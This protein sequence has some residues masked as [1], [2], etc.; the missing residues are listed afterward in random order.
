MTQNI[1][2]LEEIAIQPSSA[3]NSKVM[4]KITIS[5]V[6]LLVLIYII[7]AGINLNQQRILSNL[8]TTQKNLSAKISSYQQETT[9]FKEGSSRDLSGLPPSSGNL[10]GF[11]NHLNDLTNITP[12]GVWLNYINISGSDVTTIKGGTI[13]TLGISEFINAL[14]KTNSWLNKKFYILQL[15]KNTES[16]NTDFI[17]STAITKPTETEKK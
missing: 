1:N 9:P 14:G 10:V 15:N 5:F 3:F 13:T 8:E 16:N 17:I 4:T 12:T 6:L 11:Y 2:L 7:T